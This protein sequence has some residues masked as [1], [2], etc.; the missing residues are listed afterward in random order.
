MQRVTT[1]DGPD[2]WQ[3]GTLHACHLN[4]PTSRSATFL[5]IMEHDG[6]LEKKENLNNLFFNVSIN[7]INDK[8]ITG[9]IFYPQFVYSISKGG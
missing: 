8:D 9:Q 2:T 5:H 6:F 4:F 1:G 3:C 7:Q